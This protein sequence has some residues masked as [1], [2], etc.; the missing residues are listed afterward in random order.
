[1][2]INKRK[3]KQPIRTRWG[4]FRESARYIPQVIL[5]NL[6]SIVTCGGTITTVSGSLGLIIA[7]QIEYN[8]ELFETMVALG[9]LSTIFG[10][11]FWFAKG[12][13][14][15]SEMYVAH[16]SATDRVVQYYREYRENR[17][18]GDE[19]IKRIYEWDPNQEVYRSQRLVD[20][21]KLNEEEK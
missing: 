6:A 17:G 3:R 21:D 7:S 15:E 11:G 16:A 12:L 10:T 4:L 14:S 8:S 19:L 2:K 9:G 20:S 1:M 18:L 13:P 5:E